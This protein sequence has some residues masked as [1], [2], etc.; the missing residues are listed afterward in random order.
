M[1]RRPPRS[2]LFPY[3]TLFRSTGQFGRAQLGPASRSIIPTTS[4]M[5]RCNQQLLQRPA[6]FR[7]AWAD[8][9]S[10][11]FHRRDLARGVA[12]AARDDRAGVAHAAARRR[13]AAGDEAD[14]RLAAPALGLGG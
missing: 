13:S 2:T 14:H 7:W 9:Y 4:F 1:I 11:R 8:R 3:T 12:L 10:S 6:Q 5:L